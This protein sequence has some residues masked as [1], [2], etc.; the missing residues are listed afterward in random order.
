LCRKPGRPLT[1]FLAELAPAFPGG[2]SGLA[3][4]LRERYGPMRPSESFAR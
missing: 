3:L 4:S 2:Y 1:L